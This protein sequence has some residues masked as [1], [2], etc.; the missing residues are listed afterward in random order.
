MSNERKTAS[1]RIKSEEVAALVYGVQG[2]TYGYIGNFERWG[3]DRL[4]HIWVTDRREANGNLKSLWC[5]EANSLTR[6][7]FSK[8]SIA[9]KVFVAGWEAATSGGCATSIKPSIFLANIHHLYAQTD[10]SYRFPNS[11]EGDMLKTA[12]REIEA[13]RSDLAAA[14]ANARAIEQRPLGQREIGA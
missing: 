11:C 12:K 7:E 10:G 4:L 14:F 1:D 3:D 13:L 9:V 2:L 5:C 6:L 8:A